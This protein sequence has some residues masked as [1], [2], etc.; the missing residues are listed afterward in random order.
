MTDIADFISGIGINTH[1][2]ATNTPYGNV[3]LVQ[4]SLDYLGISLIRDHAYN[5]DLGAYQSL[6]AA[7][8]R[9]DLIL[10]DDPKAEIDS[11]AAVT[12]AI[13]AFEGPNEVD[14]QPVLTNDIA[15]PVAAALAE[16]SSV[17]A[18][19]RSTP[20]VSTIPVIAESLADPSNLATF[21]GNLANADFA[22][23]HSYAAYGASP[24]QVLADDT[25]AAA[26]L[27]PLP[28]VVTET[29]Y[30]TLPSDESGVDERTQASLTL[31]TLFDTAQLGVQATFL[32]ELLDEA[33][34]PAGTDPELH[35]GLFNVDGSPKLAA[36]ALHNLT[37]ILG[38]IDATPAATPTLALDSVGMPATGQGLMLNA[39][40]GA[41][42][43]AVWAEPQIWDP[44]L[45]QEIVAPI[46]PTTITFG[47][48]AGTV[49]VFDPLVGSA[50]I[51]TYSDVSS[52]TIGLTDHPILIEVTA[53]IQSPTP[54]PSN[55]VTTPPVTTPP[56]TTPPVTTPPVVTPPVD[57][58]PVTS[59]P[60]T[61]PPDTTTTLTD[62]TSP[63][64]TTTPVATTPVV[65]PVATTVVTVSTPDPAPVVTAS[66]TAPAVAT[67]AADPI[68]V[69]R[70]F[71][72][73][74]GT[75]FYTADPAEAALVL[76]NRPDLVA[77]G[78]GLRALNPAAN[79][80]AAAPVFRFFDVSTGTHFFTAS[81][82]ERDTIIK[83][84][85]DL[86]FEPS[87]IFYEHLEF[88]SGDTAVYRFFDSVHGTHFYTADPTERA[89]I[90]ATRSDLV[91]EGIGF[92][93][94][95]A[96]S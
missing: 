56:V 52:V 23:L 29:G 39:A 87:S 4:A 36:T 44:V 8:V 72:T 15:D 92:Y 3:D 47:T 37:T 46:T 91:G 50:P 58:P 13:I 77:D 49:T 32:Y 83:T 19:V 7:G 84:R 70:F 68:T 93:E 30:Y 51:A 27:S 18:A 5:I 80:P 45:H 28:V 54:P 20:A 64:A 48:M 61:T 59:P 9:L 24:E 57:T 21:S 22:N 90:L 73:S 25:A 42:V 40:G 82:A 78:A 66:T 38:T 89:T 14:Y 81:A 11:L 85:A 75:H 94:P 1:V 41:A 69:Y 76:R 6:A 2:D 63:P 55:P 34:D 53:L 95:A 16:Q 31:D 65:T 12:P 26:A 67:P 74:N 71:D 43:V 60:V 88:Q 17:Y 86:Q 96:K 10:D 79:D 33:T 62:P 35:Y